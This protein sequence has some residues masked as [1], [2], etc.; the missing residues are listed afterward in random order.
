MKYFQAP[1]LEREK[2]PS[3]GVLGQRKTHKH[4]ASTLPASG[5]QKLQFVLEKRP[6]APSPVPI[7]TKKWHPAVKKGTGTLHKK[8]ASSMLGGI[9]LSGGK[10]GDTL[11]RLTAKYSVPYLKP[12]CKPSAATFI[13]DTSELQSTLREF[14]RKG[15]PSDA[16][17][18]ILVNTT[19]AAKTPSVLTRPGMI[20]SGHSV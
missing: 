17:E 9:G 2:K 18:S 1:Q 14:L 19:T 16:G 8:S 12:V 15:D 10:V 11:A 4:S 13:Q 6:A 3:G 5:G 7:S 20:P